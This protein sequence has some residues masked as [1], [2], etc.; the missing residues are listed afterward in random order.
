MSRITQTHESTSFVHFLRSL[1]EV[2]SIVKQSVS[3]SS[4][5]EQNQP[6]PTEWREVFHMA[7]IAPALLDCVS[8]SMKI[9]K[10]HYLNELIKKHPGI[11]EEL[12]ELSALLDSCESITSVARNGVPATHET[13]H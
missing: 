3:T 2:E 1:K 4:T 11:K 9:I 13:L 6:L 12:Q 5:T 8:E 7:R 10:K